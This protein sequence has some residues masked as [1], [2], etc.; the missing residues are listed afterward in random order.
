[1]Q[2]LIT[3]I[4]TDIHQPGKLSTPPGIL[5]KFFPAEIRAELVVLPLVVSPAFR[6]ILIDYHG[7][8]RVHC[9]R[10]FLLAVGAL[11]WKNYKIAA[12]YK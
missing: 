2:G 5:F 12:L 8:D 4:W 7:A 3:D 9:H 10:F 11:C 6:F 1:M